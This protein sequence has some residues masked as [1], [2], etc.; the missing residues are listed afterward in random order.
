[1]TTPGKRQIS[2]HGCVVA[3]CVLGVSAIAYADA[4]IPL[5]AVEAPI[6]LAVFIPVVAVEFYIFWRTINKSVGAGRLWLVVICSNAASLLIG[7]PLSWLLR[8]AW[9][10][11]IDSF[12]IT[13]KPFKSYLLESIYEGFRQWAWVSSDDGAKIAVAALLGLLPAYYI[14]IIIERTINRR[15]M[16]RLDSTLVGDLTVAANSWSYALLAAAAIVWLLRTF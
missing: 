7:Y 15:M 12:W 3:F 10:F 11:G 9:Q 13:H 14:S 2:A 6:W 16:K 8:L 1:M 4:G 5:F